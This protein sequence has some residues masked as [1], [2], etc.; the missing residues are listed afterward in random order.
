MQNVTKTHP[1]LEKFASLYGWSKGIACGTGK[2][3]YS[4]ETRLRHI[5]DYLSDLQGD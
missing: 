2:S 3:A 4:T 5:N 1:S